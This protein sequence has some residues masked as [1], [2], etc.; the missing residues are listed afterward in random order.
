MT[1]YVKAVQEKF[2]ISKEDAEAKY[3]GLTDK[4]KLKHPDLDE[5]KLKE[6]VDIQFVSFYKGLASTGGKVF[7]G[8]VLGF[9]DMADRMANKRKIA[10]DKMKENKQLAILE[11]YIDDMGVPLQTDKTKKSFGKPIGTFV[12]RNV[13]GIIYENGKP[14]KTFVLTETGQLDKHTGE[15][16]FKKL[17]L[18][19]FVQFT[20]K[21]NVDTGTAL[22]LG[23]V[24]NKVDFVPVEVKD[25]VSIE[26]AIKQCYKPIKKITP[27]VKEKDVVMLE[28]TIDTID[29]N[30]KFNRIVV[31]EGDVDLDSAPIPVFMPKQMNYNE[32]NGLSEQTQAYI[33]GR[34]G[35]NKQDGSLLLNGVVVYI[36]PEH[37]ISKPPEIS[38]GD[39][40]AKWN[41]EKKG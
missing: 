24:K 28:C 17:P 37:R 27:E 10:L 19:Q 26:E 22:D 40:T 14:T 1:D 15:P 33:L 41:G 7:I 4:I 6:K 8:V 31:S 18:E 2:G 30:E 35:K 25:A 20:A 13:F 36:L 12:A 32:I 38:Q 29:S 5:A 21:V 16:I 39:I 34:V 23:V 11:G 9:D 3:K